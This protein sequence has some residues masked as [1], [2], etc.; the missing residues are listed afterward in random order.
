MPVT[1][2]PAQP[3]SA[4]QS[5]TVSTTPQ[6]AS[7]VAT[8]ASKTEPP[9]TATVAATQNPDPTRNPSAGYTDLKGWLVFEHFE[10][11][12]MFAVFAYGKVERGTAG[13]RVVV[14]QNHATVTQ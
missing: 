7:P 10:H 3:T 13:S 2:V 1:G 5:S 8:T 11:P 4:A 6:P 14:D 9:V 12:E